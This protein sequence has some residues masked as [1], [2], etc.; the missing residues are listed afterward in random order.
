[1]NNYEIPNY[2]PH[3]TDEEWAIVGSVKNPMEIDNLMLRLIELQRRYH[4]NPT[5]GHYKMWV[6]TVN[7]LQEE[8]LD[9]AGKINLT[10]KYFERYST[11]ETVKGSRKKEGELD[12]K[13]WMY[14]P[15]FRRYFEPSLFDVVSRHGRL[16]G[17]W[18]NST[19]DYAKENGLDVGELRTEW[20]LNGK[21]EEMV[22]SFGFNMNQVKLTTNYSA[23]KSNND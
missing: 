16:K 7:E 12:D 18:N 10:G 20:F 8:V 22:N 6:T 19:L 1:M 15:Y 21:A 5:H 3:F 4:K 17:T 2:H 13:G 11:Q 14:V 23:R 9:N